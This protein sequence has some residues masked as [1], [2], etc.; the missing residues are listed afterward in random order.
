MQN[1]YDMPEPDYTPSINVPKESRILAYVIVFIVIISLITLIVMLLIIF[2][3]KGGSKRNNDLLDKYIGDAFK[4]KEPTTTSNRFAE[5]TFPEE[6][7]FP[8]EPKF[9]F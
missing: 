2:L 6:P 5:R 4:E 8:P 9:G 3:R 7:T 1:K